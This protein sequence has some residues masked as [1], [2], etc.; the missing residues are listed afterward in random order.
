MSDGGLDG[1]TRGTRTE[2][3]TSALNLVPDPRILEGAPYPTGKG[4]A[5]RAPGRG[6]TCSVPTKLWPRRRASSWAS[7]TTLMAFSVK[8]CWRGGGGG[9]VQKVRAVRL[10]VPRWFFFP[11]RGLD[12]GRFRVA[13][14]R[15]TRSDARIHARDEC[16]HTQGTMTSSQFRVRT[17]EWT[18]GAGLTGAHLEHGLG[19]ETTATAGATSQP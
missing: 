13:S 8:R 3:G 19:D 17:V 18:I 15:A 2:E 11:S 16:T 14:T 4:S 6:L 10:A 9:R 5:R 7:M 12:R 1:F